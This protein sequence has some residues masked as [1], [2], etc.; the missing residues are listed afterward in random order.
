[1]DTTGLGF[2]FRIDDLGRVGRLTGDDNVRAKILQVL[3]T[4]PGERVNLPDFG[5][6]LRD[7][8]FDPNNQILAAT[9]EFTVTKALQRW[10]GDEILV[11]SVN[12]ANGASDPSRPEGEL[13]IEV[14]YRRRD[15]LEPGKLK[16]TF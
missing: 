9:T 10:V 5:C 15:R 2:P 16:I 1:M 14:V 6:G 8:V 7:L 13:E 4:A 11:E 12:V 3:L